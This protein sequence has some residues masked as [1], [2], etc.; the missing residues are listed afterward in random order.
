MLL[1]KIKLLVA[2]LCISRLATAQE[3]AAVPS[4]EIE[5]MHSAKL[6]FLGLS[7]AYE[8]ALSPRTSLTAELMLASDFQGRS[9]GWGTTID[10]Y[11]APVVNVEPRFYYNFLKRTAK[12]KNTTNNSANYVA[13]SADYTFGSNISDRLRFEQALSVTP[14]WGLRRALGGQFFFESAVG[15]SFRKPVYYSWRL[16]PALNVKFGYVF[17]KRTAR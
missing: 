14:K 7:Y 2:F 16:V 3:P 13:L 6:T 4:P 11:L 9:D 8:R 1:P 17:G 10:I 15:L 5:T 12:G